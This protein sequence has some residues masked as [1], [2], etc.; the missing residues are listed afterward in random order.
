M[1]KAKR[2]LKNGT[3]AKAKPKGQVSL[4]RWDQ[5]AMGA[6]NRIGLVTE[7]RG[8]V[9]ADTGETINPNGVKG[10]RRVDM[11][12]VYHQR[13][14]ITD[15]GYTAGEALRDA[16]SMVHRAKGTDYTA[17]RVDSSS[18]PDAQVAIL[19]DR[20]SRYH[21]VARRIAKGDEEILACVV[22]EGRAIAHLRQYRGAAHDAGKRHL[23]AALDRLALAMG[24]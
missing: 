1:S 22:E 5:G 19:I 2:K 15:K 23:C 24:G 3:N 6:A 12:E 14:W 17:V 7:Q 11:L 8:H 13:G 10:V 16:W 9:D 20:V 21:A 4:A 18:K